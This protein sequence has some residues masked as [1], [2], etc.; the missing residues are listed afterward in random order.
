MSF[1][2]DL[3]RF[4]RDTEQTLD[5]VVRGVTLELGNSIILSSPVDTGR[6]RG[7]WQH[8]TGSPAASSVLGF[9]PTGAQ[10]RAALESAVAAI[11]AGN[12]EWFTNNLPYGPV[13]ENGSSTQAPQGMVRINVARF[14][15]ILGDVVRVV[16]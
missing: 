7:N 6:F 16:S 9:D 1:T 3:E 8:N 15:Q 14:N 11:R 10:A 13:L 2:D 5:Q 4:A 12:V